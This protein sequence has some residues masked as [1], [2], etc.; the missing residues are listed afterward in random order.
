MNE[1]TCKLLEKRD[2]GLILNGTCNIIGI[3]TK[4]RLVA[5]TNGHNLLTFIKTDNS[6]IRAKSENVKIFIDLS[7]NYLV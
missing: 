7:H 1:L 6:I 3:D 5:L 4:D 2:E